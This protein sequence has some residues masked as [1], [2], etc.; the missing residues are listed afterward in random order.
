M[1]CLCFL[2]VIYR[3]KEEQ[4]YT[5]LENERFAYKYKGLYLR[6]VLGIYKQEWRRVKTR[7]L[8]L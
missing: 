5:K 3:S 6:S 7:I 4:Y 2:Y 8:S 1:L